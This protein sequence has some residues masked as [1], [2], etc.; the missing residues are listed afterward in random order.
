[1]GQWLV[2]AISLKNSVT[3]RS[4]QTLLPLQGEGERG[5]QKIAANLDNPENFAFAGA[6]RYPPTLLNLQR[7][8]FPSAV[9]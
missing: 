7:Q 2:A 3:L 6:M 1:L 5:F 4:S 8:Q 9:N